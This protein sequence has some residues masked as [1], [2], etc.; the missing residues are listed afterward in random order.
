MTKGIA[1]MAQVDPRVAIFA[2]GA[3]CI[4]A[5]GGMAFGYNVNVLSDGVKLDRLAAGT[6]LLR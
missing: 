3:I 5:L 1:E 2:I 6:K 4:V